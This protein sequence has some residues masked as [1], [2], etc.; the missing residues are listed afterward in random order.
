MMN[1]ISVFCPSFLIYHS[2]FPSPSQSQSLA[3]LAHLSGQRLDGSAHLG[4]GRTQLFQFAPQASDLGVS[5]VQA[6][7]PLRGR[8]RLSRG[9]TSPVGLGL[10]V[11]VTLAEP[12]QLVGGVEAMSQGSAAL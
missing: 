8:G 9:W 1:Q 10:R 3:H 6:L 4:D 12:V 5:L 2:S 11:P 7:L